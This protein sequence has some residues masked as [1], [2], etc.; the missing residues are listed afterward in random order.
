MPH[1]VPPQ[2]SSNQTSLLPRMRAEVLPPSETRSEL[3]GL[4]AAMLLRAAIDRG[5]VRD[6]VR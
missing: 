5:E 6:E 2:P 4:L 3:V 1:R